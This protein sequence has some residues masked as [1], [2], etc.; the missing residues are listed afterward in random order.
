MTEI[1]IKHSK[2]IDSIFDQVMDIHSNLYLDE[3]DLVERLKPDY[4]NDG[5]DTYDEGYWDDNDNYVEPDRS[6][7]EVDIAAGI[8]LVQ[9]AQSKKKPI[10]VASSDMTKMYFV[11]NEK[12][13]INR[14]KLALEY[15]LIELDK[16]EKFNEKDLQIEMSSLESQLE[17]LKEKLRVNKLT[18]FK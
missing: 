9:K 15:Y 17:L 13:I 1:K 12:D 10:Y 2:K 7:L 18:A 5:N 4:F 14:C 6:Y 8:A 16:Q 3:K 11:E